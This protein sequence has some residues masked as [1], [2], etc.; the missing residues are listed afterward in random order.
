MKIEKFLKKEEIISFLNKKIFLEN[1]KDKIEKVNIKKDL[2]N[3][4]SFYQD[5]HFQV[6]NLSDY[7]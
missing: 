6:M 7:L 3:F 2:Y 4:L 5:S 1:F